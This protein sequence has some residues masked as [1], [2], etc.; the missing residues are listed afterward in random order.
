MPSQAST[1]LAASTSQPAKP[2]RHST[3]H[4]PTKPKQLDASQ[5]LIVDF[6]TELCIDAPLPYQ[7]SACNEMLM[8]LS[9]VVKNGETLD[10]DTAHFAVRETKCLNEL[11]KEQETYI[12]K[13]DQWHGEAVVQIQNLAAE[14]E[15]YKK[16]IRD[17]EDRLCNAEAKRMTIEVP[18]DFRKRK[19]TKVINFGKYDTI[20]PWIEHI[21]NHN[22]CFDVIDEVKISIAKVCSIINQ[23]SL[24]KELHNLQNAKSM[25]VFLKAL[26]Y[27]C[28]YN[29]YLTKDNDAR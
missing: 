11:L 4:R 15:E 13:M 3:S 25:Q 18:E 16:Q 23:E 14:N 20:K 19:Q 17:L 28:Y 8:K 2:N 22:A 27:V 5:K 24:F 26:C 21:E 10:M 7:M 6:F 1:N 12:S 29:F 9:H